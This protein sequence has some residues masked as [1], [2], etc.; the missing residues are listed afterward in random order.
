MRNTV[1]GSTEDNE[2]SEEQ[3]RVLQSRSFFSTWPKVADRSDP[4][5]YASTSGVTVSLGLTETSTS[6]ALPLTVQ[7]AGRPTNTSFGHVV[8]PERTSDFRSGALA[9]SRTFRTSRTVQRASECK[10]DGQATP[11]TAPASQVRHY[12]LHNGVVGSTLPA[13]VRLRVNGA[14]HPARNHKT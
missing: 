14:Q 13:E 9:R 12:P 7:V 1:G 10:L 5:A 3:G 4:L 2:L 11:A 6:P 8:K